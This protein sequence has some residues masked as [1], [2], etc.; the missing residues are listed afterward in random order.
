TRDRVATGARA[1]PG[2]TRRRARATDRALIASAIHDAHTAL[3]ADALHV[4]RRRGP[5]DS[6]SAQLVA[7]AAHA[8]VGAGALQLALARIGPRAIDGA[9]P[10]QRADHAAA[11]CVVSAG[12]LAGKAVG[13]LNRIAARAGCA[14]VERAAVGGAVALHRARFAGRAP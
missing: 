6:A 2:C 1:D 10:V 14:A 12:D 9:G 5:V 3:H 11:A 7:R 4:D 8:A 13:T